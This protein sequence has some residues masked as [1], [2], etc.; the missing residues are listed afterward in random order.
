VHTPSR[1]PDEMV[2]KAAR[3]QHAAHWATGAAMELLLELGSAPAF[4]VRMEAVIVL[5]IGR[6]AAP[7]WPLCRCR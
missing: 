7:P 2:G 4:N 3:R 1:P 6:A 5:I